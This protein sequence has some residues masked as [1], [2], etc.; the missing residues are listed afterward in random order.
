M[1][2]VPLLLIGLLSSGTVHATEPVTADPFSV[3]GVAVDVVAGDANKARDA[4]FRLAQR[5]AWRQLWARLTGQ[6]ESSAPNLGDGG[7]NGLVAGINVESEN[8][9]SRRYIARLSVDFEPT[10]I[11]SYIGKLG[12]GPQG[13]K[14]HP[15]LLLP[16]LKDGG[17]WS[18]VDPR[19][20]WFRAWTTFADV[21]TAIDYVR[22]TGT[23]SDGVLLGAP[24]AT[25]QSAEMMRLALVRYGAEDYAVAEAQLNRTY[26]GGPVEGTFRI[27]HGLERRLLGEVTLK[28]ATP[29][30][31]P[32]MMAEAVSKLDAAMNKALEAGKLKASES[33]R[34][35]TVAAAPLEP[36]QTFGVQSFR[37][38][39]VLVDTPSAQAWS[40]LEAQLRRVQSIAGLTLTGLS[41]GGT[42]QVRL[43]YGSSVDWLHYDLDQIGLRLVPTGD[44]RLAL[45]ARRAGDAPIQMPAIIEGVGEEGVVSAGSPART[46]A[47]QGQPQSQQL[48]AQA[49]Q[50]QTPQGQAPQGQPQPPQGQ[51]PSSLLPPGFGQRPP[52]E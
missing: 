14:S 26:P 27:L 33:I 32:A 23:P 18:G 51:P 50:S 8:F 10:Q 47:P 7:M 38:I 30:G 24:R 34:V 13:R 35:E 45:R 41:L 37:G 4:G 21:R 42:S 44:G 11:R 17:A 28:A 43:D 40:A 12:L 36:E 22:V 9:S 39:D 25:E 3:K 48:P 1:R 52:Q 46:S 49:P 15:I 19:S 29:A 16:V 2:L 31:I 6:S 5:K 20:P